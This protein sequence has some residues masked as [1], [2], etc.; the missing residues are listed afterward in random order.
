VFSLGGVGLAVCLAVLCTLAL[1]SAW[2]QQ[3]GGGGSPFADVDAWAEFHGIDREA[4]FYELRNPNS[5]VPYLFIY[6]NEREPNAPGAEEPTMVVD[7]SGATPGSVETLQEAF[8]LAEDGEIILVL[9]TGRYDGFVASEPDK[10]VLFLGTVNG[11]IT[12]DPP[13]ITGTVEIV[14]SGDGIVMLDGFIFDVEDDMAVHVLASDV[15]ISNSLFRSSSPDVTVSAEYESNLA[16]VHC[17]FVESQSAPPN[18]LATASVE[19]YSDSILFA[20]NS[21]FHD[22]GTACEILVPLSG[23]WGE[24]A[25]S[26]VRDGGESPLTLEGWL[27][28][29]SPARCAAEPGWASVDIRQQPR[30][31]ANPNNSIIQSFNNSIP[32]MGCDEFT[33]TTGNG[34]P[35]WWE[36]KFF[37]KK[38]AVSGQSWFKAYYNGLLTKG[39]TELPPNDNT[40]TITLTAPVNATKL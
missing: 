6:L 36:M 4:D 18:R 32:S 3:G 9:P 23:E 5:R 15:W 2:A 30:P 22:V 35:D 17:T 39:F 12:N 34:Y 21:V 38:G 33:D 29:D 19:V 28:A 1:R 10:N 16:L 25:H 13:T 20:M 27:Y 24:I 40:I 14:D 37:G 26:I 11:D 31:A 8:D 7:A